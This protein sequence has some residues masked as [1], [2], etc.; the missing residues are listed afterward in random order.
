MPQTTQT[1]YI[2]HKPLCCL[3]HQIPFSSG[4]GFHWCYCTH[5]FTRD[6]FHATRPINKLLPQLFLLHI[7]PLP[8]STCS[9]KIYPPRNTQ[10]AFW[11]THLSAQKSQESSQFSSIFFFISYETGR[12]YSCYR[13]YTDR[14]FTRH[15]TCI[16]CLIFMS[17]YFFFSAQD[18]NWLRSAGIYISILLIC[19]YWEGDRK[20]VSGRAALFSSPELFSWPVEAA[21]GACG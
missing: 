5:C 13:F 4:L 12:N 17:F 3:N 7:I 20:F 19:C 18:T 6:N 8:P 1:L 11:G 9:G 16:T 2:C 15:T 10:L 21:F 14:I